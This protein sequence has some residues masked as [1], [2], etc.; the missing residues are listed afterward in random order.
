[1]A[2][3]PPRE[4]HADRETLTAS[5]REI[6]AS[7]LGLPSVDLV[8]AN[9]GFF[10]LGLT[11]LGLLE[12]RNRAQQL[13]GGACELTAAHLFSHPTPEALA[14]VRARAGGAAPAA[15]VSASAGPQPPGAVA[16]LHEPIAIIGMSCRFPAGAS[17]PGAFWRL[18][19]DGRHPIVPVPAN[20]WDV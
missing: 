12:L 7:L 5:L 17:D 3:A 11:S 6:I 13:V 8:P 4:V 10:E 19:R 20:R 2:L 15:Q 16:R 14:A 1:Q 9:T 18:L